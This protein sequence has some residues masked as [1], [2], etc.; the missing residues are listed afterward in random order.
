MNYE[1]NFVI[2][3]LVK[4]IKIETRNGTIIRLSTFSFVNLL[5]FFKSYYFKGKYNLGT[6]GIHKTAL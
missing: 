3:K 5:Y 4:S 2:N 6:L 1:N